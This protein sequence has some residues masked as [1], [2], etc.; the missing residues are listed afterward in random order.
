MDVIIN[1]LAD[2]SELYIFGAQ[3]SSMCVAWQR[4]VNVLTWIITTIYADKRD[5]RYY[6]DDQ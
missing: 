3:A 6:D 1:L 5:M 4:K 2:W